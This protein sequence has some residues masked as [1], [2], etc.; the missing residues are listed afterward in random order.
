MK[1]KS[2]NRNIYILFRY[3]KTTQVPR[4]N[5]K[6][7]IPRMMSLEVGENRTEQIVFISMRV[8]TNSIR[9]RRAG[10]DPK[11]QL[12]PMTIRM[13][14]TISQRN[15]SETFSLGCVPRRNMIEK[16]CI[17]EHMC[18]E[19]SAFDG[20]PRICLQKESNV[21]W[22][23]GHAVLAQS[24]VDISEVDFRI[25]SPQLNTTTIPEQS[26]EAAALL[27][28]LLCGAHQR[29]QIIA[30]L[31]V[32]SQWHCCFTACSLLNCVA[33]NTFEPVFFTKFRVRNLIEKSI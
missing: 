19:W 15:Q 14:I 30:R 12:F 32:Y 8:S 26:S 29:T 10:T 13:K 6:T 31:C 11:P 17:R 24:S 2:L 16:A 28:K 22:V 20:H 3:I 27:C 9:K 21:Y 23:G 1:T 4:R 25:Y 5:R 33:Y 7:N 18:V